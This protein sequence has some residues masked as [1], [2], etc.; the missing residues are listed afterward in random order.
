MSEPCPRCRELEARVAELERQAA[1]A[2]MTSPAAAASNSRRS[3]C[4]MTAGAKAGLSA[5]RPR[6]GPG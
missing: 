4:S 1:E 3:G 5:R 2:A 6:D